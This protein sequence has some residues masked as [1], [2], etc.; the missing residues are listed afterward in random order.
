MTSQ[1]QNHPKKN[2]HISVEP[3]KALKD[4]KSIKKLLAGKPRDLAVFV[5][6][7]NTNL[8]AG[9]L[10]SITVDQV[11]DAKPGDEIHLKESKTSKARRITLNKSVVDAIQAHIKAMQ[12][13]KGFNPTGPL[14]LSQRGDKA[15]AVSSLSRLVK[16]WCK[17]INL[18]GN[19]ASHSLRKTW[20]YH[21]RVTFNVGIPELMTCFNHSSQR[22]T[23]DYLC[24]QPEEIR[25]VYMNEL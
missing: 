22:Q 3:L 1:S 19:Y 2:S 14:F 16:S 21:Q 13:K 10:L 9:D 4:I 15:L 11:I 20:G 23:L 18:K 12:S 8:R 24:I 25:D 6:G 7:I 5:L 17:D